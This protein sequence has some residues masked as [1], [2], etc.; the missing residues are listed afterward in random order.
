M[1]CRRKQGYGGKFA[2]SL[3][4]GPSLG[5]RAARTSDGVWSGVRRPGIERHALTRGLEAGG[6]PAVY[7]TPHAYS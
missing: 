3:R 6:D 4:S 7:D 2:R 5:Q 1:P